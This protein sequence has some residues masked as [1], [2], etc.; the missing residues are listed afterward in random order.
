M[1]KNLVLVL[2]TAALTACGTDAPPSDQDG[3]AITPTTPVVAESPL[4]LDAIR[5]IP[6]Q[7]R[8]R[9][10]PFG[11]YAKVMV[12]SV[13]GRDNFHETDPVLLFLHWRFNPLQAAHGR[14]I[15]LPSRDTAEHYGLEKP[16][17][18]TEYTSL[19]M[20]RESPKF[21]RAIEVIRRKKFDEKVATEGHEDEAW[22]FWSRAATLAN[23]CGV[24]PESPDTQPPADE[25]AGVLPVLPPV[26]DPV[27]GE[28]YVFQ[29]PRDIRRMGWGADRTDAVTTAMTGLADSFAANDADAFT[30]AS[31]GLLAAILAMN[32]GR[33]P[34]WRSLDWIDRE[35]T[36]NRLN[37][38]SALRFIYF[39]VFFIALC[40]LPLMGLKGSEGGTG[41][42]IG[43]IAWAIPI[44]AAMAALAYHT[45]AII[46][47]TEIS[48][49]AMIGNLYESFVF[50][51]ASGM[52]LAL[53]FEFVWR[54]GWL[55]VSGAMV[56]MLA[57]FS[58]QLDP[59]F[60]NPEVSKL[61][62]VLINNSLI[63]IHVPTIMSSYAV[64]VLTVILGHVYLGLWLVRG[65]SREPQHRAS[66]S[67][68]ATFMFWTI[69]PGVI[70][71]FAG[72]VLGGVWADAS[73]GRFW[74]NDPKEVAAAVTFVVFVIV[75]HGRWAGWL[76]DVGTALG[77]LVGGVALWWTWWGSNVYQTGRH[78]Y[79]GAGANI[80]WGPLLIP[81]VEMLFFAFVAVIW[82]QRRQFYRDF[83][84]A[85]KATP[86]DG[87]MSI[88]D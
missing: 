24:S 78:S 82:A 18:A 32:P 2:L 83:P 70:L 13:T 17:A 8:L 14:F 40:A 86:P 62:P 57:L 15:K 52:L 71:L 46:E 34:S 64:L 69:P 88:T 9:Y 37:P 85:D 22:G 87:L 28:A 44:L 31:E 30:G 50:A 75:I 49:R 12:R 7:H 58:A 67:R 19:A 48:G 84:D 68:I 56:A 74:G 42:T 35:V 23:I 26:S 20:L 53:I 72:I 60:M 1:N 81:A 21:I 11:T 77:S 63:H 10:Q 66:L 76:R 73:W 27:S 4:D 5:R 51:A 54:R 3:K 33:D 65:T 6:V 45:W 61:Q 55:T 16:T 29:S 59:E 43:R 41:R 39:G 47:R 38:F 25:F 79:A 36:L 80:P